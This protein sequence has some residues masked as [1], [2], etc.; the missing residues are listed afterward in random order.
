MVKSLPSSAGVAGSIPGHGTKIPRAV[1]QLSPRATTTELGRLNDR[2]CVLQTT[3]PTCSGACMP[4]LERN[5]HTARRMQ[6]K[7]KKKYVCV[8]LGV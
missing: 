4:Q 5:L 8:G 3:E 1:G 2:A 7:K 6:P